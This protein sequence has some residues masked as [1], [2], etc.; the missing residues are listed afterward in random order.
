MRLPSMSD[1]LERPRSLLERQPSRGRFKGGHDAGGPDLDQGEKID[2]D[3]DQAGKLAARQLVLPEQGQAASVMMRL[4]HADL[5]E[6]GSQ[7]RAL[8][9]Q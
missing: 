3:L 5:P 4:V 9:A 1:L 8:A 6:S 2:Q 7:R